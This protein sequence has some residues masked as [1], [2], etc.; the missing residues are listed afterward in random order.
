[1]ARKL[2]QTGVTAF[3]PTIATIDR[4]E[5]MLLL[6]EIR[7]QPE[8]V[9]RTLMNTSDSVRQVAQDAKQRGVNVIIL[10]ACGTSDHAALNAQYLFQSVVF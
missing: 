5:T 2:P 4:A 3:F 1:M 10:A 6:D 7:E 9:R 8:A